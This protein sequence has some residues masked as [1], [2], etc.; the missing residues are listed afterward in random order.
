MPRLCTM[1]EAADGFKRLSVP[2]ALRALYIDFEGEKFEL[3]PKA[4]S[5][6]VNSEHD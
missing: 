5:Y 3:R 4:P 1:T 2:E 6:R